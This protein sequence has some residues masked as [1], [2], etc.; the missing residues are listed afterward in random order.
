VNPDPLRAFVAVIRKGSLTA[1]AAE[2]RMPKSSLSRLLTA[3]EQ[4]LGTPLLLRRSRRLSLT[5]AGEAFLLHA[6]RSVAA[7]DDAR[8]AVERV[9]KE[10]RGL[11]RAGAPATFLRAFVAPILPA[12]LKRWPGLQVELSP[13]AKLDPIRDKLDVVCIPGTHLAA[14]ADLVVRKLGEAE[15]FL[16]AAPALLK[17][18]PP[19][20]APEQL[21][22]WPCLAVGR[23]GGANWKLRKGR[24]EFELRVNPRVSVP[25]P[26]VLRLLVLAGLGAAI[27]PSFFSAEDLRLGRL[28]RLLPDWQFEPVH[29]HALYPAKPA[30]RKVEEFLQSVTRQIQISSR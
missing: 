11:L 7:A 26:E 16:C 17:N 2:L 6:D 28:V 30:P 14:Q 25:D 20:K 29:F 27:L 19:L 23:A 8:L 3:L 15:Q 22:E 21:P 1:A 24:R 4:D 10:P 5:E 13:G 9:G 18:A 12:L